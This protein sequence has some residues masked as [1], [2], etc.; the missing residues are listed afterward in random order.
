MESIDLITDNLKFAANLKKAMKDAGKTQDQ[1]ANI[2]DMG[3]TNFKRCLNGEAKSF[4]RADQIMKICNGLGIQP[5]T[6]FGATIT[7][8]AET[9]ENG[10]IS[11]AM[12]DNVDREFQDFV[13]ELLQSNCTVLSKLAI[14]LRARKE[15]KSQS[16]TPET[17]ERYII[18][19]RLGT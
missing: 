11:A 15:V 18:T 17:E 10:L 5:N 12:V 19:R 1:V 6:L 3:L 4:P 2:A 7:V 13:V 16:I 8:I 9:G 14:K